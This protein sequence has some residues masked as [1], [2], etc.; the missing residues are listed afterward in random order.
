MNAEIH[1]ADEDKRLV[2]AW[3]SVVTKGG[4]PVADLQGDIIT[5]DE[6]EKA[7]HGFMLNSREAGDMHI[8]TTGVGKAVESVVFSKQMQEALGVDL[9]QE[10]WFVVMKITDDEVWERVKKGELTMLSIGGKA[11][12]E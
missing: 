7:A 9:G 5:I 1:K 2:Y 8:K 10:G 12:R 4:E 3:A 6:L 11:K